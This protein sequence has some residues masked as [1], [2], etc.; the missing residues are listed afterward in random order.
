MASQCANRSDAPL[1]LSEIDAYETVGVAHEVEADDFYMGHFIEKGTRILPLD[2][3]ASIRSLS[4][5][6][7]SLIHGRRA[8]LRNPVNYPDPESFRPERW[9]DPEW[10]S[11]REPLSQYPTVKGMTS[12]GWGQ[13][14]CL[15]QNLTQDEMLV[16]CGCVVWGF[17]MDYKID[18]ATGRKVNIDTKKSNSLLIVKPDPWQMSITPRS[19]KK[20]QAMIDLWTAAEAKE[21]EEKA[22]FRM[23]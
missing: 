4:C 3:L 23:N 1:T 10:P 17:N 20:R 12:F 21:N 9:M 14:A 22:A 13:R 2:W 16:A 8:F 6:V 11:Y 5:I 19:D 18:P 7:T 15:G